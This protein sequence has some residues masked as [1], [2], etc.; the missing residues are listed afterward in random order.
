MNKPRDPEMRRPVVAAYASAETRRARVDI[1]LAAPDPVTT[2][3]HYDPDEV[4][5][6]AAV[7][8]YQR[9]TGRKFPTFCEILAVVKSLGYSRDH[10]RSLP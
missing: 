3:R 10:V 2:D 7:Q 4:E 9:Q 5:F 1:P 6:L 8:E